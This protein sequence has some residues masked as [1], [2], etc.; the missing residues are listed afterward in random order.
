MKNNV[1][2]LVLA[3]GKG[4]RMKS[5]LPKVLHKLS[6]K[7]MINHILDTCNNAGLKNIFIVL[8]KGKEIVEKNIPKKK[9]KNNLS[10]GTIGN[11]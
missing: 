4:V 9:S 3:A 5:S 11:G 10:R 8:G 2:V 6:G 1:K 7:S